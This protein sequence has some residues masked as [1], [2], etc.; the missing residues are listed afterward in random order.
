M[1]IMITMKRK[2]LMKCG[3]VRHC[4]PTTEATSSVSRCTQK[5][6]DKGCSSHLSV[7]VALMRGEYDD[8]LEWPFE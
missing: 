7:F 6:I 2:K 4:I 3:T 8:D 1:I 5:G